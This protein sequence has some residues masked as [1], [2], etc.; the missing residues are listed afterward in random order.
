M[1][2]KMIA[3]NFCLTHMEPYDMVSERG[4]IG[5]YIAEEV[6]E[7]DGGEDYFH[8]DD[9][10][11]IKDEVRVALKEKTSGLT[12]LLLEHI[13]DCADTKENKEEELEAIIESSIEEFVDDSV[14]WS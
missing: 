7:A 5:C 14:E 3:P 8:Y 6:A 4:C 9:I 1:T 12:D 2:E 13:K 11:S 10:A